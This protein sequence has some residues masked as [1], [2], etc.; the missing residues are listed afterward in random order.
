[1]VTTNT[2]S[3]IKKL[4]TKLGGKPSEVADYKNITPVLNKMLD[5]VGPTGVN[6]SKD[7]QVIGTWIDGR[8]IYQ[9]TYETITP[10][11]SSESTLIDIS[12]MK[13]D[14]VLACFGSI[15]IDEGERGI[16][17]FPFNNSYYR[18]A[19]ER[20]QVYA[21]TG[22]LDAIRCYCGTSL[23]DCKVFVTIQYTKS[24]DISNE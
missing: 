17:Y 12:G 16:S 10:S 2:L 9:K 8:P 14:N 21:N 23:S 3:V 11:T 22:L 13:L 15:I 1:M 7:E 6:Y 5:V 20:F 24:S 4:F 19:Q 18:S